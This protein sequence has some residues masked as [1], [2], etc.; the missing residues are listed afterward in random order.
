MTWTER[1]NSENRQWTAIASSSDG[2][3]LAAA[4][5]PGYIYTSTNSGMTWTEQPG[6]V[7]ANWHEIISSADGTKLYT[8]V[9]GHIYASA[10]SGVTWTGVKSSVTGN[11]FFIACSSDGTKLAA[12]EYGGDIS[13]SYNSGVTWTSNSGSSG[14]RNWKSIGLSPDGRYW[15]PGQTAVS[16]IH[17]ISAETGIQPA[18]RFRAS[19][20]L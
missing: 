2:T 3:K 11:A 14:V 15:P 8:V 19:G 13:V 7:R 17:Q 6:S 1:T 20:N 5:D 18:V 9:M 4:V 12:A 10:D 16:T